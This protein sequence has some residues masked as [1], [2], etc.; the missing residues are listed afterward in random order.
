V[1]KSCIRK[2]ANK[3]LACNTEVPRD[4]NTSLAVQ[5]VVMKG[6]VGRSLETGWILDK[7]HSFCSWGWN[8]VW[9]G[10]GKGGILWPDG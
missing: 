10:K 6:T 1:H 3:F 7:G 8:R 5:E 9:E 2:K 4:F